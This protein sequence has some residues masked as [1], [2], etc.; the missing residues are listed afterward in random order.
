LKIQSYNQ[1]SQNDDSLQKQLNELEAKYIVLSVKYQKQKKKLNEALINE[2][3]SELTQ[4]CEDVP[5][6]PQIRKFRS[7]YC[8]Y[9]L[10]QLYSFDFSSIS[11]EYART[12][13]QTREEL[14]RSL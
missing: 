8:V 7:T 1:Q 14:M 2:G 10:V 4:Q 9:P 5:E 3:A 13:L 6:R 11:N 12:A